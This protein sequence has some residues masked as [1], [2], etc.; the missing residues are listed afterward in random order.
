MTI[1]LGHVILNCQCQ[2][3]KLFQKSCLSVTPDGRSQRS[4]WENSIFGPFCSSYCECLKRFCF[5]PPSCLLHASARS[6]KT[7]IFYDSGCLWKLTKANCLW[8]VFAYPKNRTQFVP[9]ATVNPWEI[10]SGFRK[11]RNPR[12]HLHRWFLVP[13]S[14]ERPLTKGVVKLWDLVR[15]RTICSAKR[16]T[17]H[18]QN[19]EEMF[20][21]DKNQA[22]RADELQLRKVI[23]ILLTLH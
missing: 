22:I 12:L 1:S 13:L 16:E 4:P 5:S 18:T 19:N 20:L 7:S 8:K 6:L 23:T 17:K 3:N 9:V 21:Q 11:G 2:Q 15:K 14:S 10:T